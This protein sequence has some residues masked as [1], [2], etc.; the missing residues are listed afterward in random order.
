MPEVI[1]I[2]KIHNIEKFRKICNNKYYCKQCVSEYGKRKHLETKDKLKQER[3]EYISTLS[4]EEII[5]ICEIHGRLN[6]SQCC[7]ATKNH[8]RCKECS[9]ISCAKSRE[10]HKESR[11]EK[12]RKKRSDNIDFFRN[13][14]KEYKAKVYQEKKHLISAG[15]KRY[16]KNNPDKVRNRILKR[17]YGITLEHYN[18]MLLNQKNLCMIC[19]KPE[20]VISSYGKLKN[21]AV[22]HNHINGKVRGLLCSR[23]NCL[24]GYSLEDVTILKRTIN[25]LEGFENDVERI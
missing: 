23:C 11:L 9:N 18:I 20:T 2:C 3:D 5:K 21:L 1:K 10:K 24:I 16:Y 8:I 19:E 12:L 22:D 15:S 17:N 14:D 7:I 6:L 25:Y 13:R 4:A